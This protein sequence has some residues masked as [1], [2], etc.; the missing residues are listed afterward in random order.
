MIRTAS[1]IAALL[2]LISGARSG[3]AGDVAARQPQAE[4]TPAGPFD[5]AENPFQCRDFRG[6]KV[7]VMQT[8]GLGDV[9][10]SR[11]IGRIP[12]IQMDPDRLVT[13][14]PK[15]QQFFFGHECA[16][17]VLAHNFYPTPTVEVDADCWSIMFGRDRGL[18][19]RQDVEAFAPY[20]AQSKG[21]AAGHLPGPERVAHLLTCFDD[22]HEIARR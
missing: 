18:F 10:R 19:S 16:H 12:Y 2:L 21:S 17:H 20:F 8:P 15:L 11:I 5:V 22:P 13:L 6:Q 14:P 3:S 7:V 1:I 9:A 4:E